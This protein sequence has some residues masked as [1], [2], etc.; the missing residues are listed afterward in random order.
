MKNFTTQLL[1]EELKRLAEEH[2]VEMASIPGLGG[3]VVFNKDEIEQIIS[4][5]VQRT[6]EKIVERVRK[7]ELKHTKLVLDVLR[8]EITDSINLTRDEMSGA[9]LILNKVEM[10]VI[11]HSSLSPSPKESHDA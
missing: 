3:G 4:E 11:D 10:L 5:V 9:Y 2:R 1:K 7:T 6:V 8:E